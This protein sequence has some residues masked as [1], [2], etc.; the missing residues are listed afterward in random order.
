MSNV[1]WPLVCTPY[2]PVTARTQKKPG[3]NMSSHLNQHAI[4]GWTHHRMVCIGGHVQSVSAF[5]NFHSPIIKHHENY[6]LNRSHL[7]YSLF[8]LFSLFRNICFATTRR[9]WCSVWATLQAH[10]FKHLAVETPDHGWCIFLD[11]WGQHKAFWWPQSDGG[12]PKK[13][14]WGKTHAAP[15]LFL[16]VAPGKNLLLQ[17]LVS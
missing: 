16:L 8:W 5:W 1:I 4:L 12:E 3:D 10:S 17:C 11:R 15:D 14:V 6:L 2:P 13:L 7:P 9:C